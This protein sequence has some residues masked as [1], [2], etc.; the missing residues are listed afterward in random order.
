MGIENIAMVWIASIGSDGRSAVIVH[1]NSAAARRG[2]WHAA[3]N[4]FRQSAGIAP[5][6]IHGETQN[7]KRS[8]LMHL[9]F[10]RKL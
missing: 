6:K 5:I 4:E 9:I 3:D 2:V 8:L 10:V 7:E 1:R